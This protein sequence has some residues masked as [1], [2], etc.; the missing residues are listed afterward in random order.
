MTQNK[1]TN[2][3]NILVIVG[4]I[5]MIVMAVTPL[6]VNHQLNME[7]MR[8]IFIAGALIVLVGRLIDIYRGP[9]Q[10]L[11]RL[12]VILVFSALLYCASGSMMFIYQGT[13]NWIAFLLAGLL[14]QSYAS[15]QIEREQK[16]T[17][18]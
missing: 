10:R 13:N 18:E 1:R 14:V 12:H 7:W 8:W 2:I 6:L 3:A 17:K 16:K 15:W 4:M 9:S 5:M 11:K